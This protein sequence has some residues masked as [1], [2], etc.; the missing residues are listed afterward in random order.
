MHRCIT[1][2]HRRWLEEQQ[3]MRKSIRAYKAGGGRCRKGEEGDGERKVSTQKMGGLNIVSSGD[4][5]ASSSNAGCWRWKLGMTR[6][7]VSA[8]Q[9]SVNACLFGFCDVHRWLVPTWC[10]GQLLYIPFT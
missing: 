6:K 4:W 2:A 8:Q 7:G 10:A 5:H 9:G 3:G 1:R